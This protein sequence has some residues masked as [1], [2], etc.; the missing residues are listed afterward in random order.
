MQ[1]TI[2]IDISKDTFDI[3][4]LSDRRLERFGNDK[5]GLKALLR[6]IGK[7]PVPI[8]LLVPQVKLPKRLDLA[9][10]AARALDDI[11]G[12]IVTNWLEARL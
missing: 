4:R 10:D 3:H 2:G 9:R 6:W 5:P 12:L 8:F 7:A 11:P 1:D